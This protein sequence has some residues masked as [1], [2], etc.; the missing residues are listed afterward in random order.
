[1]IKI[2]FL[3]AGSTVFAKNVLGDCL[4]S[5]IL[6]DISIALHDIDPV[7]L[8][9]SKRM[10]EHIVRNLGRKDVTIDAFPDRRT[11]L[12]GA[13]YVVNF[14]QVAAMSPAP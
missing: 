10:L 13:Q 4:C 8:D 6:Q 3:G 7:R 1:M 5:D 2:A 14:I 9:D 11:A 12:D